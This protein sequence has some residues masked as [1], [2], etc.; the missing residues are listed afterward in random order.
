[1]SEYWGWGSGSRSAVLLLRKSGAGTTFEQLA[2][3][4]PY[5]PL[6]IFNGDRQRLL[7]DTGRSL[8]Y[9]ASQMAGNLPPFFTGLSYE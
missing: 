5:T 3:P 9:P 6:F 4:M 2:E 7:L 8:S 1:V